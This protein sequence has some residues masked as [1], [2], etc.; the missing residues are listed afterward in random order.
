MFVVVSV[1]A[2][3][4]CVRRCAVLTALSIFRDLFARITP[5]GNSVYVSWS[6]S[7]TRSYTN[8][9]MFYCKARNFTGCQV[10]ATFMYVNFSYTS[11]RCPWISR[12]FSDTRQETSR[13]SFARLMS[14][15]QVRTTPGWRASHLADAL[16]SFSQQRSNWSTWNFVKR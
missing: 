11:P 16:V 12:N 14:L 8:F 9:T 15:R 6:L 13:R 2:L 3:V 5:D 4:T 10:N 7:H 1:C